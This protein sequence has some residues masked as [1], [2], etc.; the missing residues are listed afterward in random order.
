[1]YTCLSVGVDFVSISIFQ[2]DFGTAP[3][4]WYYLFIVVLF[5][6][7]GIICLLWYYLFIVVLFVYC[8][9]I[10]LL[11][12]DLFNNG[13]NS[14]VIYST[15]LTSDDLNTSSIAFSP[16]ILYFVL[17]NYCTGIFIHM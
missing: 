8:G 16:D 3:T 2:L 13:M 15:V 4:V 7:C 6:Y 10:C 12:Y 17:S 9:M 11:W 14:F 5:V 1:M